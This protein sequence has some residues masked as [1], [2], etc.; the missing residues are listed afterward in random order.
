MAH[1]DITKILTDIT[2]VGPPSGVNYFST[3]YALTAPR[4]LCSE[5]VITL[6]SVLAL[7]K[8][9]LF[10]HFSSSNCFRTV[11]MVMSPSR[12]GQH[13]SIAVGVCWFVSSLLENVFVNV[14]S[15]LMS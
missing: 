12:D 5:C 7:L 14:V 9:F 10:I 15:S 2:H 1:E 11:H 13:A 4:L 8:L 6:I 3:S